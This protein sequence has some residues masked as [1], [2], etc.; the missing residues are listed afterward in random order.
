VSYQSILQRIRDA[1][2]GSPY[3]VPTAHL[4][5]EQ[6]AVLDGL[7]AALATP[8]FDVDDGRRQVECWYQEGTLDRPMKYSA[9]GVIAASPAVCDLQAATELASLQE[10]A[11]LDLGGSQLG[12]RLASVDRHRGVIAFLMGRYEIALEGF[13]RAMERERSAENLCN[14]LSTLLKVG[15]ED[16]ARALLARIRSA[17]PDTIRAGVE[18][19][20]ARDDDLRLLRDAP[21]T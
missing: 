20:M 14:V 7:V 6:R 10:L 15:E 9:L 11:A 8:G 3:V 17:F 13:V 21:S 1:V 16:E 5:P 4:D 18:Q 2:T 12:V 19:A